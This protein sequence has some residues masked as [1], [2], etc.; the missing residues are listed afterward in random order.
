MLSVNDLT[1]RYGGRAIFERAGVS[2]PAGHRVGLV[3]RN[4][5]GKST[6]LKLVL[7]ELSPDSGAIEM[8]SRARVGHLAQEA[9]AGPMSLVEFVLAADLERA[10]LLHEAE[11]TEDAG[12]I[13][14]IHERLNTIQAHAAPS[15]AATILAGLGFDHAAQ[16][17]PVSDY[18]G[19][20]RMRVALAAVLFAA[21]DLMLLDE[22]SNHLDL[23]ARMWL[24]QF[25]AQYPGTLILVS[26]DRD[27]LNAVV[28]EIVHVDA[29]KLV[30][31]RGDYDNFERTR[32]MRLNLQ[33]AALVK[34]AAQRKHI[35][36]F[37]NRFRYKASKARQAQSRIKMLE[38]MGEVAPLAPPEEITFEFPDPDQL[39]PPIVAIENASIGYAP[40]RP[41]LAKLG[42]R[43]DMD[44]RIALLGPNGNGK[45]TLLKLLARRLE[46]Q[47]GSVRRS[48]KL[49]VGYFDQDQT[50]SFD[51]ER[52]AYD[53]LAAAVPDLPE[54]KV[55]SHLGRFG[56]SQDRANRKVGQLSGGE[57][58]RLLFALVTRDA[59][60]LLLLDEPTNHL[61]I[62][63]RDALVAALS[64]FEGAVIL[65]SHDPRMVAATADRLW[66]VADGTC[67]P[68]DG[69][70]GDYRRHLIDE[71][72]AA[73]R[74][75]NG[76][77]P[78]ASDKKAPVREQ[79]TAKR[80]VS[81]ADERRAAADARQKLKPLRQAVAH[82]EKQVERLT[83]EKQGL[84]ARLADP[85]LY[86]GAPAEVTKIQ[87]DLAHAI[88]EL[89]A[90]E[91]AWLTAHEAY[92]DAAKTAG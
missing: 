12:R 52:T 6:L 43:I 33:A 45:S 84:E 78:P 68:F 9:P 40:G 48:G 65:V 86:D 20:W 60:H 46:P 51:L 26:H 82:A 70:L 91:D 15:R 80:E 88:H 44:D 76:K 27:L 67:K 79:A 59:P 17:R 39:A 28:E 31:Y 77:K 16:Q 37:I 71:R 75:G 34:Q 55:R 73:Q 74:G 19:G 2:I 53:H 63:A 23:E 8:P 87:R 69:D 5:S 90:A 10:A 30:M 29:G 58:A 56:F 3:G 64:A 38:R 83:K 1:F 11:T 18:S 36:A 89:N 21:P 49:R 54:V 24:E 42:L 4:G 66:L 92:E 32:A 22:P 72:R 62:E 85:A 25:L 13:A 14:E 61:D 7:G 47:A 57:R 50:Q 41:V 35:Q 81:K